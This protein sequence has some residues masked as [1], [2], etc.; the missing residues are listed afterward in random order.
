M[1]L[2]RHAFGMPPSPLRGRLWKT[3]LRKAEFTIDP[4]ADLIKM[5]IYFAVGKPNHTQTDASEMRVARTVMRFSFFGKMGSTIQFDGEICAATV[6]VDNIPVK[7]FLPAE[8]TG[9]LSQKIIPK[10]ILLLG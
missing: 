7:L 6:K 3:R 1:N 8:L 2:I 4:G 9:M 5:V 10:V